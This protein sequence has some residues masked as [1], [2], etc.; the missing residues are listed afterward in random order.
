[1]NAWDAM[2]A[3]APEQRQLTISTA[4]VAGNVRLT[5]EDRGSGFTGEQFGKLFQPFYTTKPRGL[6][7]GLSISRAI[8]SAHSGRLWCTSRVGG[9]ATF[10]IA[11]PAR[12]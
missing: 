6:G 9:G 5:V 2:A 8:I 1:M 7:L 4:A 10:H 11:L 12:Q 3:T